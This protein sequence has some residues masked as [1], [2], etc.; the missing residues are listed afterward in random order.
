MKTK[1][2]TKGAPTCSIYLQNTS[3]QLPPIILNPEPHENVLDLCASPGSKTTQL[4]ALMHNAGAIAAIEPDAIRFE[5]LK[6]N[7]D[8]LGCNIVSC[9]HSSGEKF[10]KNYL[11]CENP[12]LFDKILVDAPCSG[13]GTFY[14]HRKNTFAYW[15]LAFVEKLSKI[16]KRLLTAA[17]K[18]LK[19]GGELVYSTCSVSPEENEC[20]IDHVIKSLPVKTVAIKHSWLK[21]ALSS[22][23]NSS[24]DR[25]IINSRRIYPSSQSEGFFIS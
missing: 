2:A 14:V 8:Q 19:P 16:Q 1:S 11:S 18:V 7:V 15:N 3:S 12:P 10:I 6:H 20:V 9:H 25:Q 5:R 24:F 17:I 22:W 21:P 4:A 13:D 23:Q